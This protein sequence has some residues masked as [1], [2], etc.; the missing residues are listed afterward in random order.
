VE[1]AKKIAVRSAANVAVV[2]AKISCHY[3]GG[4][5]WVSPTGFEHLFQFNVAQCKHPIPTS[6]LSLMTE[7]AQNIEEQ[8]ST[9]LEHLTRNNQQILKDLR[10]CLAFCVPVRGTPDEM[11]IRFWGLVEEYLLL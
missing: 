7:T 5:L 8:Y 4:L 11:V 3:C 6:I 1:Q 2:P 9:E 10:W